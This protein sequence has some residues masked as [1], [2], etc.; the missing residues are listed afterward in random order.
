MD[1]GDVAGNVHV[2][3][4]QRDAGHGLVLQAHAAAVLNVFDEVVAE[5]AHAFEHHTGGFLS[6]GA[7]RGEVDALGRSLDGVD[8]AHVGAAVQHGIEKF[9]QTAEADAAGHAL[10]ARLRVADV[11]E[12]NGQIDRTQFGRTGLNA[13]LHVLVQAFDGRLRLILCDD[14]ESAHDSSPCFGKY[15]FS[16]VPSE[17]PVQ[18]ML[19]LR[20]RSF[21]L[22]LQKNSNIILF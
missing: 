1:Q 6:D 9:F 17:S 5:A 7:V 18:G 15:A 13:A 11:Q 2:R 19:F 14:A 20:K 21:S 12:R 4:A 3:R 10:A 8:G 22:S 16:P